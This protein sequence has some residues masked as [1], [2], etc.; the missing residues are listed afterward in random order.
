MAWRRVSASLT[1]KYI[2]YDGVEAL[3]GHF[4]SYDMQD[5]VMSRHITAS[6]GTLV[7]RT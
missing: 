7:L 6:G 4:M 5:I 3:C 2:G 1:D